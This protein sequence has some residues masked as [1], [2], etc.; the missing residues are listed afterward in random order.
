METKQIFF[1]T[2]SY[3]IDKWEKN[4]DTNCVYLI[5]TSDTVCIIS[6]LYSEEELG[7]TTKWHSE[8]NVH[9]CEITTTCAVVSIGQL[10]KPVI[11][12]GRYLYHPLVSKLTALVASEHFI[13]A[14]HFTTNTMFLLNSVSYLAYSSL[15]CGQAGRTCSGPEGFG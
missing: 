10:L 4:W 2:P 7:H 9:V 12:K 6:T 8:T 13:Q 15:S 5:C 11:F 3:N 1:D 14:L